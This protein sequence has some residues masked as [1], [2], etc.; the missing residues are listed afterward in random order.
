MTTAE[1]ATTEGRVSPTRSR[2]LFALRVVVSL[3]AILWFVRSVD[4]GA[5]ASAAR[6]LPL[7][8]AL[9]AEAAV[10]VSMGIGAA[11][12]RALLAAY[13]ARHRPSF[14]AC[15]RLFFV[16]FFYNTFLP[17]SVAGDAV[18]AVEARDSFGDEGTTASFAVVLVERLLGLAALVVVAGLAFVL[19]PLAGIAGLEG[20]ATL[21][22]LAALLGVGS[23][24][25]ARRLGAV[26]PGAI[27][28]LLSGLPELRSLPQFGSAVVLSLG[29][30]L[31][32]AVTG[33]AIISGLAGDV[34]PL[35]SAVVVP[36]GAA[37]AYVPI[38]V[39][40]LGVREAAFARLYQLAGVEA[41]AAAAFAVVFLAV[42]LVAAALGGLLTL[43]P[44]RRR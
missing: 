38:T 22:V 34:P 24:P 7:R 6:G 32:V 13:G 35:V 14:T 29:S 2:G 27:G 41:D 43:D 42:Q 5:V 17:G 25:L 28:R 36:V 12:H 18:R 9:V 10:F 33:H 37:A 44:T 16:G 30:Q 26:L 19:H 39:S 20:L 11:R 3:L 15:L 40:G 4:L 8:H 1:T 31:L 23:V 21:G